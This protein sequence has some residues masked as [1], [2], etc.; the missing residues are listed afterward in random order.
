MR[1]LYKY[2]KIHIKSQ[3]QYR[4]SFSLLCFGQ[5]MVPFFAIISIFLMFNRFGNIVGWKL[6]EVL[7]IFSIIHMSYAFAEC[8]VRGFDTFSNLIV[9][10]SFDRILVRPRNVILQ[11]LGS[12]IEFARLGKAIQGIIILTYALICIQIKWSLI[13]ILTIIFMVLSGTLIFCGIFIVM[14]TICFWTIQGLE[15][16]NIFTDGSRTLN[17]YPI[18]IY[19]KWVKSFFTFVI[20]FAC[21][22]YYPMLYLLDRTPSNSLLYAFSPLLSV[23]FVVPCILIFNLGV[24]HYKSTGS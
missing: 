17:Q 4:T 1:L 22:N 19:K 8:I 2:I 15:I 14:S 11:V 20:P 13:K 12:K 18:A 10:G 21:V 6:P 23:L 16:I 24:K 5:F 7:L 9:N 3:L